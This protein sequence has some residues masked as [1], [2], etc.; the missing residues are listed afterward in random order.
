MISAGS[1]ENVVV[2]TAIVLHKFTIPIVSPISKC[3]LC[4]RKNERRRL[5]FL[6]N[7]NT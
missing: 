7:K 3:F 4:V 2:S 1:S 5:N 6:W